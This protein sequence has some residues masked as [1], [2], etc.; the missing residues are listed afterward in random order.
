MLDAYIYD[1]LRSPFG[2]RAGMLA[3]N[4]PDDLLADVIRAV[5]KRSP[6]PVERFEDVVVGCGNQGGE[7]SRCV[8]RHAGLLAGLPIEI[9][10]T[11]LQRNCGSG[12]GAIIAASHALTS[13]EGDLFI[14]GGVE[15]MSR[16][17]FVMGKAP[18]AFSRDMEV[19]DSTVGARFPNPRIIAEFGDDNLAQTADNLAR[20]ISDHPRGLRPLRARLA[21]EIRRCR[22]RR[23]FCRGDRSD[24]GCVEAQRTG[25]IIDGR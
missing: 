19:F 16:A 10:G 8:A 3:G 5:V 4:R 23:I 25:R 21:A 2:N 11:V 24:H 6:F 22:R 13:G 17:P 18:A 14:T 1:G 7:D 12:L 9:G 20:R 15:S